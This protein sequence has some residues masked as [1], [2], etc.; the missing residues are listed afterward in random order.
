MKNVLITGAAGNIGKVLR[1][2]LRGSKYSLRLSDI[3]TLGDAEINEELAQVDILDF[4]KLKET[5]HG[6]DCVVHLSGIA[7]EDTWEK[8]LPANIIGAYN[9][10]EAARQTGVRR[11]IFA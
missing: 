8:I 2:G 9:I 3:T 10:F 1:A 6:M 7:Q 5:M 11:V 4:A